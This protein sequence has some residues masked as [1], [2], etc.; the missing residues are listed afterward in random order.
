MAKFTSLGVMHKTKEGGAVEHTGEIWVV[1]V[2]ITNKV[3][4]NSISSVGESALP[5]R[6]Y[7]KG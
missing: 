7:G 2:Q 4:S 5:S 6:S 1:Y 3:T